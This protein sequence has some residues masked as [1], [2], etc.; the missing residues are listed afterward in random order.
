MNFTAFAARHRR[1]LLVLVAAGV[2][3]GIMGGLGLPVG[4]FPNISFPRLQVEVAAGDRPIDQTQVVITRPLELAVRAVPGVTDVTSITSRGAAELKIAFGWGGDMNLALQ[5]TEAAL[6]SA[7]K[8]LPPGVTFDVRRMDPTVF[9]VVAYSLTSDRVGPI[10]LRRYAE[11]TLTPL[12]TAV[13]GVKNV[14]VVGGGIGEY[15]VIAD[16][17]KLRSFGVALSDVTQA[18]AA[19]NVQTASGKLQDRGKLF[20]TLADSRLTSIADIQQVVIKTGGGGIVRLGDVAAVALTSAPIFIRVTADGRDAVNVLVYQQPAGDTVQIAHDAAAVLA[21]AKATA[22][23][24]IRVSNWYDQSELIKTSAR[25]LA[26]AIAIGAVLAGLT[27]LVFLRNIGVTFVAIVEVPI[28][29]ALTALALKVLGQSFNIMTLG[30]MAAAIGLIID[31][32]IVMIEHIERRVDSVEAD[33]EPLERRSDRIE[34]ERVGAMR[35][36]AHEFFRPLSG[37]SAATILIFLPLAFLTGVTGAFFKALSLTMAVAL[38]ASF[39]LAWLVAPILME[40]LY[41][42]PRKKS[43]KPRRASIAE[44]Y[45]TLLVRSTGRSWIPVVLLIPLA[46]LGI[47]AFKTLPSGFMPKQDEGGFILDYTTPPGTSLIESDRLIRQIEAIVHATPEV[48]TYSRRTGAQLGGA[49]TEPNVGDFFIRL[50]PPPR[51]K[52]EVVMNDVRTRVEANVP[53]VRVETAQLIE[54]LIGDLTSVPQ[55]IEVKLFDENA[56][57]L[58]A[59]AAR[60]AT[61]LASVHGAAEVKDGEV[62]AGDALDVKIDLARAALEGIAPAEASSQLATLL[63]GAVATQVQSGPLLTDVR[64]WI[65]PAERTRVGQIADL[66]LKAADGHI[67]SLSRIATVVT[68]TGQAEIE[69]EN[70]RRMI[71]VTARVVGSSLGATAKAVRTMLNAPGALPPGVTFQIGGLAAQQTAAFQGLALVFA[72]AIGIVVLLLLT[73]YESFRIVASIILMPLMAACAVALGLFVTH[74][75]LNIMALMG[76]TMVIGIVTEVAIFYFTEYDG[77]IAEGVAPTAALIDAGVNRL[78]PIAMTTV[79]AILALTPLALGSSM[80]KPLAIAIIAGLIAQGPLVLLV[81]P[82]LYKLIGGVKGKEV[83]A[84]PS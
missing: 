74:V 67:F 38:I 11:L 81:M 79:A 51:R 73:I 10:A 69:R 17:A 71:P 7:A 80:Q 42:K 32:A 30:G 8:A 59:T 55:P 60:V 3:A 19:A 28:V 58:R 72:A 44:G 48:S 83:G 41:R 31:D 40:R 25:S 6:A 76:L 26:E 50:K 78:R 77:L 63:G 5:R 46:A 45:R 56:A 16:P 21:T 75:E 66:P 18:L 4:L 27:L 37:S 14:G 82:A 49:L 33:L 53:G 64:V 39:L 2:L 47:L 29:L 34:V 24:G 65:P 84:S 61:K 43:A 1:S 70:S 35:A 54:D 12:L 9:P 20:L 68:L 52:I 62:V 15:R 23:P 13:K 57:Q 22:P 36:A